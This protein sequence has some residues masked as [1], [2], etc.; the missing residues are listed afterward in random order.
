M[1]QRDRADVVG[2]AER[3]VLLQRRQVGGP[4]EGREAG[5]DVLRQVVGHELAGRLHHDLGHVLR[6]LGG[7]RQAG[8][9]GYQGPQGL[10]QRLA[11]VVVEDDGDEAA[12]QAWG[13]AQQVS[14]DVRHNSGGDAYRDTGAA[15]P[16]RA[17]TVAET[18]SH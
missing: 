5:E 15:V 12:G 2:V 11:A 8:P 3:G 7:P 18:R 17:S 10:D 1:E 6:R 16:R 9:P 4:V 13:G 14:T